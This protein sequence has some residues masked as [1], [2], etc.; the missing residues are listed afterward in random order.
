MGAFAQQTSGPATATGKNPNIGALIQDRTNNIVETVGVGGLAH[1]LRKSQNIQGAQTAL[2][3]ITTAQNLFTKLLNAQ[4]LNKLNRLIK[5]E[6]WLIYTSPGTT[7]PVLSFAVILGGVTLCTITLAALST[8]ATTNGP[9]HFEFYALVAST[10]TS[11]TLETHGRVEANVAAN[12]PASD[13][14]VYL[15]TNTA[16]SSAV[17]LNIASTL[18]V[19]LASTLTLTSAQLRMFKI[20]ILN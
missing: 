18:S 8:T 5:I 12:T 10:G 9:I 13:V 15:D 6:G 14:D 11:G 16:V 17:N 7:A 3:T 1:A 20:D 19:T 4:M 2:T